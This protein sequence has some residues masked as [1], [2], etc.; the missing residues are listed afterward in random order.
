MISLDTKEWRKN[1]SPPIAGLFRPPLWSRGNIVNSHPAGPGSIPGWVSFLVE[2]FPG[3][4][5]NR[6]TNVTKF[7]PHSIPVIIWP[8]Y[9]IRPLTATVFDHRCST[10]PSSKIKKNKLPGCP[11]GS[12]VPCRLSYLVLAVSL[13]RHYWIFPRS[14]IH[15]ICQGL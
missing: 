7:G 6:K 9:I 5:L 8:S 10:W 13:F 15:L 12:Q 2:V 14:D 3:F 4:S 11:A 1:S